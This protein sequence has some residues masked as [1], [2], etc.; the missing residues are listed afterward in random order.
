MQV[1]SQH[2]Y[3]VIKLK[4]KKLDLPSTRV[5]VQVKLKDDCNVVKRRN[6]KQ[7]SVSTGVELRA[8]LKGLTAKSLN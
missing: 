4:T 1:E 5:E 6:E 3:R 8:K 7:G 2:N